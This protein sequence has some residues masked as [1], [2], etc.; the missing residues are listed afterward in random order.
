MPTDISLFFDVCFR[1]EPQLTKLQE[2]D[3]DELSALKRR[4]TEVN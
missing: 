3:N 2:L 1:I 4:E